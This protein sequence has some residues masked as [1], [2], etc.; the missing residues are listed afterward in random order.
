MSDLPPPERPEDPPRPASDGPPPPDPDAG[1][2]PPPPLGSQPAALSEFDVVSEAPRRRPARSRATFDFGGVFSNVFKVYGRMWLSIILLAVIFIAPGSLLG[3]KLQMDMQGITEEATSAEDWDAE[4]TTSSLLTSMG[5]IMGLAVFQNIMGMVLAGS[6]TFL[7][8]RHQQGRPIGVGEAVRRGI[9]RFFPIAG[10]MLLV[11]AIGMAFLVPIFIFAALESVAGVILTF[12]VIIVP[13]ILFWLSVIV[14][15][16]ACAVEELGPVASIKRSRDLSKG[17]R[18]YLFGLM[19]VVGLIGG[20][21]VM[22]VSMPFMMAQAESLAAGGPTSSASALLVQ[23]AAEILFVSPLSSI[24]I[25]LAYL[26]LRRVKEGIDPGAIVS[27][28]D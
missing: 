2:T 14:V 1:Y 10:T 16:P 19:F 17:F 18:G 5:S 27:V 7:V 21:A 20:V 26:E 25:A 3:A 9:S 23:S 24:V 15:A 8:L 12:L 22:V 13:L 4:T 28:F 11:S 6:I